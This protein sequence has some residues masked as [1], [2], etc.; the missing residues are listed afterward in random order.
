M[1]RIEWGTKTQDRYVSGV[2]RGVFYDDS[3]KAHPWDGLISITE[4]P[5]TVEPTPVYNSLGL[6]YD[7]HGNVSE[8]K[9]SLVCYTYPE[10]MDEYLG[11]EY[12]DSIGAIVDERPP[13]KFNMSYRSDHDG[14]YVIHVLLGQIATFGELAH[15]TDAQMPGISNISMN[16]EGTSHEVYG[17]S[18][19]M[20]DSRNPITASVEP[21]LYGARNMDADFS[22]FLNADLDWIP[23]VINY[24]PC[25]EPDYDSPVSLSDG[26]QAPGVK[27]SSKW[28][29][30]NAI[31]YWD[32]VWDKPAIQS[33][34]SSEAEQAVVGIP[35]GVTPP[36]SLRFM[37]TL[38][39]R[40]PLLNNGV[41]LPYGIGLSSHDPD[42]DPDLDLVFE[43][44][45]AGSGLY[46]PTG[47]TEYPAGS[48]LYLPTGL[49]EN[50]A[51]SGQ[52]HPTGHTPETGVVYLTSQYSEQRLDITSMVASDPILMIYHGGQVGSSDLLF[53]KTMATPQT[54]FSG[55]FDRNSTP[56][57][58]G[59]RYRLVEEGDTCYVVYEQLRYNVRD[60]VTL[61][62]L[63]PDIYQLTADERLLQNTDDEFTFSGPQATA[64]SEDEFQLDVE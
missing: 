42:S 19:L 58:R 41:I 14:F 61:E 25:L 47:L 8:K 54:F 24:A 51:G 20:F 60:D 62:I 6:K 31:V 26:T 18:H 49:T 39:L 10:A 16:L 27:G 55:F 17:T 59:E 38:Q 34:A 57:S 11:M 40:D 50:P 15:T 37:A 64:T 13:R 46:L 52:Y 35:I 23:Y 29:L 44:T 21:L 30:Q 43:E 32:E 33:T 45:P 3:G 7:L 9:H 1:S 36:T 48:G 63:S 53:E 22:R 12:V 28:N 2:S 56:S 4:K 5:Q